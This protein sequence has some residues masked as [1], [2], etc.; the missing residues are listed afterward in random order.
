MNKFKHRSPFY[1]TLVFLILTII[2]LM[3][4]PKAVA[5]DVYQ[6]YDTIVVT[7]A[8][9]YHYERDFQDHACF[10]LKGQTEVVLD[11]LTRVDCLT[12][13]E[14][15]ELDFVKKFYECYTQALYYSAKTSKNP[16][17]MIIVNVET[18][19]YQVHKLV[20]KYELINETFG[21]NVKLVFVKEE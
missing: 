5:N 4:A 8:D 13:D 11:D 12:E 14:S 16:V 15:I 9:G 3:T 7:Q 17:C 1:I 10:I 2:V 18:P 20:D 19:E 6:K 21:L